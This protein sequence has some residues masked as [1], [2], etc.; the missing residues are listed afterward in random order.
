MRDLEH[1]QQDE[2]GDTYV[3]ACT[4][5]PATVDGQ[6]R[7]DYGGRRCYSCP[8]AAAHQVARSGLL[9]VFRAVEAGGNVRALGVDVLSEGAVEACSVLAKANADLGL[10]VAHVQRQR[11]EIEAQRRRGG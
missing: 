1:A 8:V 9:P 2:H 4:T 6:G 11:A 3:E 10:V 7:F 5:A